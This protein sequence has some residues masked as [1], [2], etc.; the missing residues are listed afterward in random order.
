M[1]SIERRRYAGKSEVTHLHLPVAGAG[2]LEVGLNVREVWQ[3]APSSLGR[4]HLEFQYVETAAVKLSLHDIVAL[5][6]GEERIAGCQQ[7]SVVKIMKAFMSNS[8]RASLEEDQYAARVN[9]NKRMMGRGRRVACDIC[10]STMNTK[11]GI[12]PQR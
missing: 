9:C 6:V 10:R 3:R 4:V 1:V 5:C 11:F 8:H 2:R 12:C 7:S